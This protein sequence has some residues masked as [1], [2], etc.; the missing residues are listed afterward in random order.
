MSGE[1][2]QDFSRVILSS[3]L[4]KA[5]RVSLRVAGRLRRL[6]Q[7]FPHQLPNSVALQEF[8][9]PED[10]SGRQGRDGS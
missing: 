8:R 1:R 9:F 10:S 2:E 5:H 3:L 7:R 4:R 6:R